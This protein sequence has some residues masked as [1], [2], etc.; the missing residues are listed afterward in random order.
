MILVR[1]VAS[2][3]E[4]VAAANNSSFAYTAQASGAGIGGQLGDRPAGRGGH[5]YQCDQGRHAD[6][7][8]RHSL[9]QL[10]S[11][12]HWPNPRHHRAWREFVSRN[13]F[14][15]SAQAV[16][17]LNFFPYTALRWSE[18]DAS[19]YTAGCSIRAGKA[20]RRK[21]FAI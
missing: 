10:E 17:V 20:N 8:C 6:R 7:A 3:E 9:Q 18:R 5:G 15:A 4:A 21:R 16:S 11:Q 14:R 2:P 19:R 1:G 13:R 12:R